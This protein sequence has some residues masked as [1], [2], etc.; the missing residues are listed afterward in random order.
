MATIP[1]NSSAHVVPQ[2]EL[3]S[4]FALFNAR[5]FTEMAQIAGRLAA[6]YPGDG[7]AWKAWGIALLALGRPAGAALRRAAELLPHDAE[8]LSSLG[9]VLGASGQYAEAA[10]CYQ[11]ALKIQPTLAYVHSN[12][13]NVMSRVGEYLAAETSCRL[14]LVHQPKLVAAHVNL[15]NALWGQGRLD[16]AAASYR[17]ALF[18]NPKQAE[19]YRKLAGVFQTQGNLV[20]ATSCLREALKLEPDHAETQLK[21]GLTLLDAGQ[22]EEAATVFQRS[23]ALQP[24]NAEAHSNLGV[25]LLASQRPGEAVAA[26]RQAVFLRPDLALARSNLANGLMR[27]GRFQESLVS[28][29]KA[30]QLEPGNNVILTNLAHTLKAS[31]RP[32]EAVDA[33][34]RALSFDENRLALRSQVIFMRN[35][36][37]ESNGQLRL[38][39]ARH[40][41]TQAALQATPFTDWSN[42]C[43]PD[44]RLR[45]GFL[46]GDFRQHPVGYF[47]ESVFAALAALDGD[48]VELFD[49]A[50]QHQFDDLSGRLQTCCREWRKVVAMNDGDL[51]RCIRADGIDVLV[52]LAG[53]TLNNRLPVLAFRP[54]PVQVSWLGYCAM[55]G[56]TEVDAFVGD[57][58][59][60]PLGAEGQFSEPI[61][62]LP[63][64][65]LCFTPPRYDLQVG[66]LPALAGGGLHF[67]CM[68]D[69]A[70]MNDTVVDVWSRVLHA[71]PGS[72]LV[73]QSAPLQDAG[74][75]REV[76]A[77]YAQKGVGFERLILRAAQP[78]QEYL[79]AYGQ[80]D[81]ALDP[82]P[83]P[84]GTTTLEALWM[85][86]PVLTLPGERALSRQG[87]RQR[88]LA[89][90]LCDAPRFA[91]HLETGVRGLWQD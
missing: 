71:V 86:V 15:G 1:P 2:Q 52:D 90:S 4:L 3:V 8:V 64:T 88:L 91:Q 85:G 58:W 51:A 69:L 79:E 62:R 7:Q 77:R 87:L 76:L 80:I 83:Y 13:G 24:L 68:N 74:V 43:R 84:G 50:N 23:V 81:I 73:L 27:L 63:H 82:F 16:E 36:S 72:L 17:E 21:L 78:R 28:H 45:I 31:G 47:M 34:K 42:L 60:A 14:A 61:L 57:P 56:L 33:L 11:R 65:F 12:L 46:S 39:E 5:R 32:V 48:K 37:D 26:L 70:K 41:G 30:A 54:A 40:F 44:K 19:T 38:E 25:A 29:E 35:Y 89:S 22:P 49:Y 59:I 55:T 75:Q 6:T 10:D 18:L 67:G 9:G 66:P 53:H 20:S